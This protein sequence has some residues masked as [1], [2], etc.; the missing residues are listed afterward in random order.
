MEISNLTWTCHICSSRRPDDKISVHTK[1][2][3]YKHGLPEGIM[4]QN[5]R[6]CNDNPECYEAAKDHDHLSKKESKN[7]IHIDIDEVLSCDEKK[8]TFKD[9][10]M[11]F[12]AFFLI[13]SL[14]NTSLT[15]LLNDDVEF[16]DKTIDPLSIVIR[17]VI[18]AFLSM[19]FAK[20]IKE[21]NIFYKK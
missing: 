16:F 19:F 13:V 21:K 10:A 15:V 4:E 9:Y 12:V 11:P 7:V 2:I 8:L 3:G 18:A 14:V 5:V 20:K 1:D 6:Y 17:M